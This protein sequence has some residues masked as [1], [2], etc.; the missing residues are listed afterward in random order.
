[1]ARS[2]RTGKEYESRREKGYRPDKRPYK[3]TKYPKG[4]DKLGQ[5][6]TCGVEDKVTGKECPKPVAELRHRCEYHQELHERKLREESQRRGLV[7]GS[8]NR[9]VS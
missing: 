7:A 1:M 6:T 3:P 4:F 2:K 8:T 9:D 5:P